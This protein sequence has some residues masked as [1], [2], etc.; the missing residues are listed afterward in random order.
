MSG[1]VVGLVVAPTTR[2]TD[3]SRGKPQPDGSPATA[4][5]DVIY[6]GQQVTV[7]EARTPDENTERHAPPA[8]SPDSPLR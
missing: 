4:D 7:P 2:P 8:G 1:A 3:A 6:P 5:P